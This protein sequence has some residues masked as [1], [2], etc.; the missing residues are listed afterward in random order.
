MHAAEWNTPEAQ[1]A[2][3]DVVSLILDGIRAR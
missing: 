3:E 1:A 2:S